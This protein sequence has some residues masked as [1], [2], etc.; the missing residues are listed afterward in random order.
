MA[1]IRPPFQDARE[2]RNGGLDLAGFEAGLSLMQKVNGGAPAGPRQAPSAF[3][4]SEA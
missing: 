1:T 2:G 3:P 4:A